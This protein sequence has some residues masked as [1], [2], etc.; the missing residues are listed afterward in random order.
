MYYAFLQLKEFET[1][2]LSSLRWVVI[3]GAPSSPDAIRRFHQH[4][5]KALLYHGWGLTET[6]APTTVI[7][8]GS[9]K[10][11]SVGRPAPW[12]EV[13]ILDDSGKEL[14]RAQ[15]GQIVV[16]GW[17]VSDGYYK[18]PELTKET[19]KSGWFYTGDLGKID[20]EGDLYIMGRIKEMIKVAGEIV[21]EPEVEA[22][23][24]KHPAVAEV[25]VI[26]VLD[27]LRGEVPKAFVV[28]KEGQ[29]LSE[30][31]LRYFCRQHL[32]HFKIPHYFEFPDSLPKNRTGK[33]EKEKLRPLALENAKINKS[34]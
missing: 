3:F 20:Q 9:P 26:G 30:E 14:P 29:T 27:K 24:H 31:E 17:I 21:F 34:V 2:D 18:N 1:F 13:K 5:P 28:L 8:P 11:E 23:I 19:F 10:I 6:N 12:I 25:A 7:P 32:A 16:R 33:V 4:C 22:A 15:I